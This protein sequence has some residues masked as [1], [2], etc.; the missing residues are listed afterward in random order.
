MVPPA[1]SHAQKGNKAPPT[2]TRSVGMLPV[3]PSPHSPDERAKPKESPNRGCADATCV[4]VK[5]R[6]K[7][8]VT[9]EAVREENKES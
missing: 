7:R 3:L 2:A 4:L 1:F 9:C 5:I 8:C 6:V